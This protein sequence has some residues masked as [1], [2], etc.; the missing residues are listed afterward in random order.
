MKNVD[1]R[2]FVKGANH[3]QFLQALGTKSLI[4]SL[5][6]QFVVTHLNYN[7]HLKA[8]LLEHF[9]S[10][11]FLKYL[12]F[13]YFWWKY[14]SFSKIGR[15][16]DY[17]VY[18]ADM[19]WHAASELFPLDE[20]FLGDSDHSIKKIAFCPSAGNINKKYPNWF[21]KRINDFDAIAVRDNS[22]RDLLNTKEP[23]RVVEV[24]IDPCFHLNGSG[25]DTWSN[26]QRK[27]DGIVIYSPLCWKIRAVLPVAHRN[28]YVCELRGYYPR[29]EF[30]KHQV[31]MCRDPLVL[32]EEIASCKL[33]LTSTFHGIMM[34]LMTRTPFVA[35]G[36]PSLNA[37]L[38]SDISKCF[39]PKRIL[40]S[41]DAEIDPDF[42]E[43][44][45]KTDDI[46]SQK[47]D[48]LA[49]NAKQWLEKA[50]LL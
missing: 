22:T 6:D 30:Y 43:E 39:N 28:S 45:L 40:K 9:R 20:I 1:I 44:V 11:S 16:S 48:T 35:V 10:L 27:N 37:R 17:S 38:S 3:G 4:E 5:S 18:G 8:E 36:N 24:F 7:N 19:I 29:R 42:F 41:I 46:D 49:L 26:I 13:R 33:L 50:I 25:Y 31:S 34:A 14:F 2:S 32:L 23:S 12:S 15:V 47:I 21:F